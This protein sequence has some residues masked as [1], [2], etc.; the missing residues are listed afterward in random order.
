MLTNINVIEFFESHKIKI[1]ENT[2]VMCVEENYVFEKGKFYPV[3]KGCIKSN[4]GMSVKGL[5]KS[6]F[7]KT[8]IPLQGVPDNLSLRDKLMIL[9]RIGS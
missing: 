7:N 8:F 4:K 3:V 9:I 1:H 2:F 6:V 5:P